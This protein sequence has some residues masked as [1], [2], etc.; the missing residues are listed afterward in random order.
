MLENVW[1]YDENG[2]VCCWNFHV[3]MVLENVWV[4]D[5]NWWVCCWNFMCELCWKICGF[6]MKIDEYVVG[7]SCV[8]CAGKC[9]GLWWKLMGNVAE[10]CRKKY[11]DE[12]EIENRSILIFRHWCHRRCV[13]IEP[14]TRQEQPRSRTSDLC[15]SIHM[16]CMKYFKLN[17]IP[18]Q[19]RFILE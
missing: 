12:C 1:V 2:W 15:L 6:L 9:V 8:N 11:I 17:I 19:M 7:I 5:K 10:I 13:G 4:F 14:S 3:K 18:I 16:T